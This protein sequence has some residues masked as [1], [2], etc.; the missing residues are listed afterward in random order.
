MVHIEDSLSLISELYT[1][2]IE[3]LVYIQL[4]EIFDALKLGYQFR[5]QQ[6]KGFSSL[7]LTNCKKPFFFLMKNTGIAIEDLKEYM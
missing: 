4:C 6:E 7:E 2:I 5:D 1:N 3:L